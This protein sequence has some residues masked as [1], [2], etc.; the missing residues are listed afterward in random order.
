MIYS[1]MFHRKALGVT[2]A[3]FHESTTVEII[4]TIIPVFIL[5]GMAWPATKVLID[6]EDNSKSDNLGRH[7]Q[8]EYYNTCKN[9]A[10]LINIIVFIK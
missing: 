7:E 9:T 1:M 8:F 10:L 5:I 2:P 3:T 4:W 6:M